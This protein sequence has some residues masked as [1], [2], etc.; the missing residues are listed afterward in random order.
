MDSS[1]VLAYSGEI[2][3][4]QEAASGNKEGGMADVNEAL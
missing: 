3:S 2:S 1:D 4:S